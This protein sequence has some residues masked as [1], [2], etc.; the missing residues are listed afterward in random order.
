MANPCALSDPEHTL[1]R[2]KIGHRVIIPEVFDKL[3]CDRVLTMEFIPGLPIAD[4]EQLQK[5]GI[6]PQAVA[7][8]VAQVQHTCLR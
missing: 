4:A 1:C 5:N 2:S 3:T 6:A 7:K 8:L